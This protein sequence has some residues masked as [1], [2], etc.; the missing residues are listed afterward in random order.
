M[1]RPGVALCLTGTLLLAILL[2]QPSALAAT[3]ARKPLPLPARDR[4]EQLL[5]WL[6]Q[7]PIRDTEPAEILAEPVPPTTPGEFLP[8][9]PRLIIIIDDIGNNLPRGERTVRLPGLVSLSI[10]PFTP[11]A[12]HLANLGHQAGKEIMLHAPMENHQ[13]HPL[14]PGGLTLTMDQ[15][16]FSNQLSASIDSLPHVRGVNNHM[17][18][19]MTEQPQQMAW[20]MSILLDRD[21][22]FVDSRTSAATVAANTAQAY[23]VP[24]LS[25]Q[26]FLD[27]V[28]EPAAIAAAFDKA[29]SVARQQG[30]AVLIGHPYPETLDLLEKRIPELPA[31]GIVLTSVEQVLEPQRLAQKSPP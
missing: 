4:H 27:H 11:H 18:S 2:P 1:K 30:T 6:Q 28:R 24:H 8:L 19:L 7:N 15:Q 3:E 31:N 10:L 17:G 16:A 13:H 23:G 14:G 29:L 12:R 21:L 26:V 9:A 5:L 25:R 22:F 20:T